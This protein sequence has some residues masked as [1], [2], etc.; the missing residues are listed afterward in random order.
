MRT[1]S[2]SW[3][4]TIEFNNI[5]VENSLVTH[6]FLSDKMLSPDIY[7][8]EIGCLAFSGSQKTEDPGSH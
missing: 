2:D 8:G 7:D 1:V 3:F 6:G 4:K 5:E